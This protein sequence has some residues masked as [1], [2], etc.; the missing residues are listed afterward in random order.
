MNRNERAAHDIQVKLVKI[1]EPSRSRT[2][3]QL[4]INLPKLDLNNSNSQDIKPQAPL[5]KGVNSITGA[6]TQRPYYVSVCITDA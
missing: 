2:A 1:S 6:D 4:R 5:N 3:D